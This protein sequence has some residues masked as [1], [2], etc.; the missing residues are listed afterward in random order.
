MTRW[1]DL[2]RYDTMYCPKGMTQG[3][4]QCNKYNNC[5][6]CYVDYFKDEVMT[7]VHAEWEMESRCHEDLIDRTIIVEKYFRCSN[8]DKR[9]E[10]FTDY[11]PN[12]GAK[13]KNNPSFTIPLGGN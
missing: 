10:K 8:C 2:D 11:C 1:V 4:E 3:S 6:D 12:C 9:Q 7:V 5:D 13:M